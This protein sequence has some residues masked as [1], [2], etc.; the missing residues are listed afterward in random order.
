[1][2]SMTSGEYE[3]GQVTVGHM[4]CIWLAVF[5]GAYITECNKL[6]FG[7]CQPGSMRARCVFSYLRADV[8]SD[9]HGT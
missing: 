2:I 5:A 4:P 1:M 8:E 7:C 9:S 3:S 6:V